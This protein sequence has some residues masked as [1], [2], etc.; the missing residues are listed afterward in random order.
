MLTAGR[1]PASATFGLVLLHGRGAGARDIIGLGEALALPDLTFVAPEAPGRSWWPTSFLAPAAQ[2]EPFLQSGFSQIESAIN[3][4]ASAG[5]PRA[6]I[7][8]LGFSQGSCLAAEY[9]S[10]KGDGLGFGLILSGGLVGSADKGA[11]DPA[12]YGHPD[13]VLGGTADLK[14]A[15][16]Y[17]SCHAQDPHI[18]HKRF[19]DSAEVLEGQ[20]ARVTAHS[21]PGPGHGI[22]E[23]DVSS[24]RKL[25]NV[26]AAG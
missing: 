16:I 9:L 22:D 20:G 11:K 8:L 26:A 1:S 14:S 7:G 2:M 25:L 6:R 24:I 18:P 10:R 15:Q 21:K 23:A 13:K 3:E 5:L 4:M 17:M 12:L 19:S